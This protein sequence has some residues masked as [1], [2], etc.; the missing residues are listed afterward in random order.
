MMIS[1]TRFISAFRPRVDTAAIRNRH[2]VN[3]R[4]RLYIVIARAFR[5]R[6]YRSR[7]LFA[8]D[9]ARVL[10]PEAKTVERITGT[11]CDEVRTK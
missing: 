11:F 3:S 10:E 7:S 5:S 1:V 4:F 6:N 8:H 9:L 2:R